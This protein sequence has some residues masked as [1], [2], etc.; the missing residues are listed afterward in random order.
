MAGHHC[1]AGQR[2]PQEA[3]A[4]H[5]MA[6]L[7]WRHLRPITP[8]NPPV[9]GI[10]KWKITNP[11]TKKSDTLFTLDTEKG[12]LVWYPAAPGLGLPWGT[13]QVGT[14]RIGP[15]G[16]QQGARQQAGALRL[17][18]GRLFGHPCTAWQVGAAPC[19]GFFCA[20]QTLPAT[21]PHPTP[22]LQAFTSVSVFFSSFKTTGCDN[23]PIFGSDQARGQRAFLLCRSRS[24][25]LAS[26][27][28]ASQHTAW[29]PA[30]PDV[31]QPTDQSSSAPPPPPAL[32]DPWFDLVLKSQ[33]TGTITSRIPPTGEGS[34]AG[35]ATARVLSSSCPV[36]AMSAIE[37][38]MPP[39]SL[40]LSL[41]P[42]PPRQLPGQPQRGD[43]RLHVQGQQEAGG[44]Q[45][46]GLLGLSW[47]DRMWAAGE[48]DLSAVRPATCECNV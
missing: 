23:C 8:P 12:V 33:P 45:G 1:V 21:E 38:P 2:N 29:P 18:R 41:S 40:P 3:T 5:K 16:R 28:L 32:Q 24:G 17:R 15:P 25:R 26:V 11:G 42:R 13:T 20:S 4:A 9:A 36:H 37:A 22:T 46:K 34:S 43:Q 14:S 27:R 7:W 19:C 10:L 47:A 30:C 44:A 48:R 31:K 39:S 6:G 35:Q